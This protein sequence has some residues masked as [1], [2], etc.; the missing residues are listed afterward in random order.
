MVLCHLGQAEA[1]SP[2]RE[3]GSGFFF[4][5]ID[6]S[7]RMEDTEAVLSGECAP[8]PSKEALAAI[9]QRAG[10]RVDVGPF[11]VR[12]KDCSH[13]V[14]QNYGGDI[15]TPTIDADGDSAESLAREAAFVSQALKDAD[16]RHRFEVYGPGDQLVAY[17]HHRWPQAGLANAS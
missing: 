14:F 9:L 7:A 8:W 10:L 13:F 1:A 17:L 6:T 3:S 16:I 5:R 11:S 2:I 12:V 15:T 4:E